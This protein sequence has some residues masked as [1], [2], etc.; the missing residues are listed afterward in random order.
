VSE[1]APEKSSEEQAKASAHSPPAKRDTRRW[2]VEIFVAMNLGFLAVD[3]Y[4]AHA[5]NDFADP[6]EWI[7]IYFSAIVPIFLLPG[8]FNRRFDQGVWRWVGI[9]VGALSIVVGVGGMFLHLESSFFQLV[10]LKSLVY[11]AP[12]VAPLSY[13]GVGFLLLLNRMEHDE[14]RGE[15]IVFLSLGGMIGNFVLSVLDHAQNAFFS[16]TEYIPVVAAGLGVGFL[17]TALFA[18][19]DVGFLKVSI[20]IMALNAAHLSRQQ[21][22]RQRHRSPRQRRPRRAPILTVSHFGTVSIPT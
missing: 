14:D 12:F 5:A 4:I 7:P 16:P 13:A 2:L 6:L 10:T 15:W 21:P 9:T 8:I 3:I 1:S 20:G 22:N 11:S 17:A 19:R 18:R